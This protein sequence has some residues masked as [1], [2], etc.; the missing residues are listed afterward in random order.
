MK[1]GVQ[2]EKNDECQQPIPDAWRVTIGHIVEAFKEGDFRLERGIVGVRVLSSQQ[3][4]RISGNL[5]A[6]GGKLCSLPDETWESSVCQWM[7][8]HWDAVIDLY[9]SEGESD[10]VLSVRVDETEGGYAFC[11]D[12]VHVP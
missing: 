8:G 6:Y 11:V 4:E 9:T 3:A 7:R 10:L 5:V 12:S 2:P 1:S